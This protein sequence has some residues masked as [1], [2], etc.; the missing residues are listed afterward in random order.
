MLYNKTDLVRIGLIR[1]MHKNQTSKASLVKNHI[2][3]AMEC[4]EFANG[5][6]LPGAKKMAAELNVSQAVVQSVLDSFVCEGV[7]FAVPRGGS[8]VHPNWRERI[9]QT[10]LTAFLTDRPWY[11]TLEQILKDKTPD[12]HLTGEFKKSIFEIRTTTYVQAHHDEYMDLANLFDECFFDKSDIELKPFDS[13]Y[14]NG[15][16][17]G[18]PFMY[19]PRVMFYN[20]EILAENGC[21]EPN[22]DWTWDDF[23]AIIMKLRDNVEPAKIIYWTPELYSWMTI[24]AR[25]GGSLFNPHLADPVRIDS[26]ETIRGLEKVQVLG[27]L[28]N[29]N[30]GK[31]NS[32]SFWNEG[33]VAFHIG[34]RDRVPLIEK[35][36]LCNW[37]VVPLP[38]IAEGIDTTMQITELLCVRK[39]CT[40][41][42]NAKKLIQIILSHE[43]QDSLASYRYGIPIRRSAAAKSLDENDQRN[44]VF[45]SE[46]AKVK[47]E[48]NLNSPELH[49]LVSEGIEI[50]LCSD[51]DIK[52]ALGQLADVVR[53]YV[54]IKNKSWNINCNH[55]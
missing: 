28:M 46:A 8:Y 23:I 24:V 19:S 26:E 17:V 9:L 54:A 41:L 13:F 35:Y 53:T 2:L 49:N 16:L 43:F 51:A 39:S 21:P 55:K 18:I 52:P 40:N 14:F 12:L 48:Y 6:R 37:K 20:P 11:D 25:N 50:C 47:R 32:R 3:D 31:D 5:K 38:L 1:N 10:N 45:I 15:K 7:L 4:G 44:A 34:G 29:R 36:G 30:V 22:P 42:D 27:Q 33:S